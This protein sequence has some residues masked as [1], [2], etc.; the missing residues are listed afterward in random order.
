M[1]ASVVFLT[2]VSVCQPATANW[3]VR[4]FSYAGSEGSRANA[5]G[6]STIVGTNLTPF[7]PYAGYW[8]LNGSWT[9][10]N[11]NR[12]HSS[13]AYGGDE[14]TQ[15][16]SAQFPD[17]TVPSLWRGTAESWVDL[18]GT[19]R[20]GIAF[21]AANGIQVG[22]MQFGR[23]RA[24]EWRGSAESGRDLHP[25][26]WEASKIYGTDGDNHVGYAEQGSFRMASLW[27]NDG[28]VQLG[29][30][31]FFRTE[32]YGTHSGTQVGYSQSDRMEACLWQGS[33]SSYMSLKPRDSDGNSEALATIFDTQVGYAEFN[34][35]ER[36][37][38]WYGS[39][40]SWE[41]LSTSLPAWAISSRA[42]A[43]WIHEGRL[44][45]AGYYRG[46]DNRAVLWSRPVPEPSGAVALASSVALLLAQRRVR[47]KR[48]LSASTS[49]HNRCHARC[50]P[51]SAAK[52][53]S[54]SQASFR[55]RT[56]TGRSCLFKLRRVD[57]RTPMGRD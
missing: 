48:R 53:S 1:R 18:S 8:N 25:G 35:R 50:H 56:S 33:H 46:G 22:Y 52:P 41:D 13:A 2:L 44:N 14:Q 21:D 45:V 20:T 38:I 37:G 47:V 4:T 51:H 5:G 6:Q 32:A 40:N 7:V 11:P 23:S 19:N 16:G 36:A 49:R 3:D 12:A 29:S 54:G 43:V 27:T 17:R 24:F 10:L 9:S 26:G 42:T 39:A 34:E 57:S 55:K 28:F 31:D 15:V 30:F